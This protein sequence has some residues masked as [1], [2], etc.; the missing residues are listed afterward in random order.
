MELFFLSIQITIGM[1]T[2]GFPPVCSD[3]LGQICNYLRAYDRDCLFSTN[4]WFLQRRSCLAVWQHSRSNVLTPLLHSLLS[5]PR[6]RYLYLIS[7]YDDDV[8]IGLER[9]LDPQLCLSRSIRLDDERLVQYFASK[10]PYTLPASPLHG[11]AI[12]AQSWFLFRQ[13]MNPS[14]SIAKYLYCLAPGSSD[15]PEEDLRFDEVNEYD[16]SLK[17]YRE[18]DQPRLV[19]KAYNYNAPYVVSSYGIEESTVKLGRILSAIRMNNLEAMIALEPNMDHIYHYIET[20]IRYDRVEIYKYLSKHP[21]RFQHNENP[22]DELNRAL[23]VAAT[24]IA[25][26]LR[27]EMAAQNL[28]LQFSRY[29]LEDILCVGRRVKNAPIYMECLHL[30]IQRHVI[31]TIDTWKTFCL[32]PQDVMVWTVMSNWGL[33]IFASHPFDLSNHLV[34]VVLSALTAREMDVT[35][36]HS[37]LF[38]LY[39][40]PKRYDPEVVEYIFRY[41]DRY[42]PAIYSSWIEMDLSG[43]V[44][45]APF[46]L[47][48]FLSFAR[49]R[50]PPSYIMRLLVDQLMFKA[51]SPHLHVTVSFCLAQLR[52]MRLTKEDRRH[53]EEGARIISSLQYNSSTSPVGSALMSIVRDIPMKDVPRYS[54]EKSS[55]N[56]RSPLKFKCIGIVKKKY[57]RTHNRLM[58]VCSKYVT[59]GHYCHL[60][61]EKQ[62]LN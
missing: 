47:E 13:M 15:D 16:L 49:E 46:Q 37:F 51:S 50:F 23:A 54:N 58:S 45:A 11:E 22:Q 21:D 60:H 8:T 6:N 17:R 40:T 61:Q 7:I 53:L 56:Q 3:I 59:K 48:I 31:P 14:Q 30:Y 24:N 36:I 41:A 62:S 52:Q 57:A 42:S 43:H 25:T 44:V 4:K 34:E 55:K 20:V 35:F 5:T 18:L 32:S 9:F 19:M 39:N 12:K 27:N 38:A 26:Y 33:H 10:V 1:S 29:D 2:I 28:P